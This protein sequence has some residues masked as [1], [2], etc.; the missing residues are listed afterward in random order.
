MVN[1]YVDKDA[2][3]GPDEEI[4]DFVDDSHADCKYD[5]ILKDLKE[6]GEVFDDPKFPA[7]NTSLAVDWETSKNERLLEEKKDWGK[8]E[9]LRPK[10]MKRTSGLSE[11]YKLF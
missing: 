8:I 9:W 11:K 7:D 6:R 10:D 3:A 1:Y 4:P 5:E 2:E